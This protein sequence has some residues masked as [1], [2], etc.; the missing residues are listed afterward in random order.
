[1]FL[2]VLMYLSVPLMLIWTKKFE[3]SETITILMKRS[4]ERRR[5]NLKIQ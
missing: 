4:N 2:R 3:N 5:M 1:M